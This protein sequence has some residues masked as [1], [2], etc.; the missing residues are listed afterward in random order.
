MDFDTM[1]L[2]MLKEQ[3]ARCRRLAALADDV[4]KARLLKLAEEYDERIAAREK[5]DAEAASGKQA[6]R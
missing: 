6:K 1:S 5:S 4:T 2:E 3:A